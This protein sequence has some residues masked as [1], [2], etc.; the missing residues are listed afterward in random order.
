MTKYVAF[1]TAEIP[2]PWTQ[3]FRVEGSN[4]GVAA[5][6][7]F[8]LYRKAVSERK[9]GRKKFDKVIIKVVKV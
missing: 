8:K 2:Y 4:F 7:A 6:R 3:D 9:N 1:V 5:R